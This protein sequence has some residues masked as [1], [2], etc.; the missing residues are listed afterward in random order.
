MRDYADTLITIP[1]Q[2]LV[3]IASRT[4]LL[5]AAFRVADD[6]L[7]QATKGISDL[8]TV[9]GLINCDFADIR[10]VMLGM[11]DALMGTGEGTGEDRAS[12]AAQH[13]ISSPLLENVSISGARSVLINVSGGPDLTLYDVNDATSKIHDAAGTD[14]NIIVGAVIDPQMKNMV[15]VTVIATGF[16]GVPARPYV[17][18]ESAQKTEVVDL[19]EA[20]SRWSPARRLL[21]KR[22]CC[23]RNNGGNGI[24]A[25]RRVVCRDGKD[26]FPLPP[27]PDGRV[28][29]VGRDDS[30][31]RR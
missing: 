13:A 30:R 3:T 29:V 20:P 15:R 2:R 23:L 27:P 12:I 16:T 7:Y 26:Q 11:G 1:N 18:E 25:E 9:A 22:P 31:R 6:V 24:P 10:T 28:G 4:T 21:S 17:R 14:A 5:T 8:I 19:F